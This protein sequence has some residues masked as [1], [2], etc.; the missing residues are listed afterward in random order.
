MFEQWLKFW[1]QWM[2]WWLPGGD[3]P[4]KDRPAQDRNQRTSST[5]SETEAADVDAVATWRP[6]RGEP[7]VAKPQADDLTVIRGFGPAI[8]RK[9]DALGIRSFSDLAEADPEDLA[10]KLAS[11]PVTVSRVQ[12]W[13]TEAK[14]RVS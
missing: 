6:T 4:E 13:V 9:L 14:K 1:R 2:F 8:A 11:R 12:E 7:P 10:A 5:A 3:E